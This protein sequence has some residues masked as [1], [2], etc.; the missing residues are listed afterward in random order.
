MDGSNNF[1]L[2][3]NVPHNGWND[4]C[5]HLKEKIDPRMDLLM[6]KVQ[7]RVLLSQIPYFVFLGRR[8]LEL[9]FASD[10]INTVDHLTSIV[11]MATHFMMQFRIKSRERTWGCFHHDAIND[12]VELWLPGQHP[13]FRAGCSPTRCSSARSSFPSASSSSSTCRHS[14]SLSS[15]SAGSAQGNLIFFHVSA[16]QAC[17]VHSCK[18]GM[19]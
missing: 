4:W 13:S 2:S 12:A 16:R 3:V 15:K 17:F 1:L 8:Y 18:S 7:Q 14:A 6:T 11:F 19:K 9:S 5:F 10:Y